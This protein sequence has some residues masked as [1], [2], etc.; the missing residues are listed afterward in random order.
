MTRDA[1]VVG[2][3]QY[4]FLRDNPASRPKHLT[5]PASDA[6][7]I[8]Q[9][10]ETYGN[11]RVQRL[12]VSNIDGKLQV[13]PNKRVQLEELEAAIANLFHPDSDRTPE[14]ALL[15]F[16]GHGL[17]KSI[18]SL[19]QG[20]L[21]TSDASPSKNLWGMSLRDLQEIL[22]KSSVQQ[23]IIW[24]DCCFSG[25]LLNFRET[26]LGGWSSGCD[27]FLI[28]ASRDY[29][30]AYQQ[31]DGKHGV[32]T[33]ALLKGLD[34]YQVPE[35]E[36][37]TNQMLAVS[38]ERELKEYYAQVKIP[39]FPIISNHGE[40]IILIQGRGRRQLESKG[41]KVE[42]NSVNQLLDRESGEMFLEKILPQITDNNPSQSQKHIIIAMA[43]VDKLTIINKRYGREVGDEVLAAV[44][45]IIKEGCSGECKTGR[46]GDDTFYIFLPGLQ[47]SEAIDICNK[48]RSRIANHRWSSLAPEL[49]VTCTFG[50]AKQWD[51]EPIKQTVVR[52]ALGFT[53][54]K[55]SSKNRVEQAPKYLPYHLK[56][57]DD[58]RFDLRDYFS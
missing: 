46:C 35:Y 21:A 6:E 3:N 47:L 2:I 29:E 33:G 28:A 22:Q 38:V 4:P 48:I 5:T 13:D 51:N 32:L 40:P 27:R 43:D 7:A 31:L 1:L 30:V 55:K 16:A 42:N 20:F 58:G 45:N 34:P 19:T 54:A 50:V 9:L 25:E 53:E 39:E 56:N 11:F 10:L 17:R 44:A 23:Q 12:P 24:L 41:E 8:A 36:W 18:G 15:F 14:T 37:I 52:A 57:D 49:R 26:N